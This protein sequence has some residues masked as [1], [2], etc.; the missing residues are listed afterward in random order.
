[1]LL[2][3]ATWLQLCLMSVPLLLNTSSN[4]MHLQL[5]NV[6]AEVLY[7]KMLM[8]PSV[9]SG[10]LI[11]VSQQRLYYNSTVECPLSSLYVGLWPATINA[12][13]RRLLWS[14]S[15]KAAMSRAGDM[16]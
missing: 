1:M 2:K 10:Q 6:A 9:T 5:C 16:V 8:P 13:S 15:H 4:V 7:C 14:A 11:F 3:S 12:Q